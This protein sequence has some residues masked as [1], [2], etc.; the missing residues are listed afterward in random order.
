MKL[1][2]LD[3]HL[4]PDAIAQYPSDKRDESKLLAVERSSGKISDLLFKDLDCLLTQKHNI[5]RNNVSVLKAR[6]FAQKETKGLVECL[7][8]TPKQSNVWVCMLR[9]AKRLKIGS[10]FGVENF[11]TAK[12]LEKNSD[13]TALVEFFPNGNLSVPELAEKIGVAPLPPYIKRDQK[14]PL[15]DKT[16]DNERYETVYASAQKRFA[17]AAPT[18]GLHFTKELENSLCSA[19][20]KF[21]DIT[22][23][24]GIG[25]F[26]PIKCDS[27]EEHKMHSEIY[28]ISKPTQEACMDKSVK[29]LGVGTT[30]V[31]A[32][33]DFLRKTKNTSYMP[34][35]TYT[36]SANLFIYPPQEITCIDSL[37]TNFHLPNSTLLCMVATFLSPQ[38]AHAL[39]KLKEVY[40]HALSK[41][42]KFFSYGD[43]MIVF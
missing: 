35:N 20:H 22:L 5:F 40:K 34:H 43:A 1:S 31:R 12:I 37:I 25:T 13:A 19:G 7:L 10:S 24:V 26:Q 28:E 42:Y 21:Y 8:L 14:N 4:P 17:A 29:R 30:T 41:D 38:D 3:F 2:D 32:L 6:I 23:N 36:D 27:V 11:F 39:N 18:A 16:L 9:P 15:Y 33:E